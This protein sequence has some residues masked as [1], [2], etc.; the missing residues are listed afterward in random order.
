MQL[1]I[2]QDDIGGRSALSPKGAQKLGSHHLS[3][4][5]HKA[6]TLKPRVGQGFRGDTIS[7]KLQ[8]GDVGLESGAIGLIPISC[9]KV[10]FENV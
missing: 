2:H 3:D 4:F 10:T 7:L 6:S 8:E 1:A 5:K 9:C